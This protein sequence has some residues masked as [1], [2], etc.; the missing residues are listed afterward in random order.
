MPPGRL[1]C[2]VARQARSADVGA[3]R[4]DRARSCDADVAHQG[5]TAIALAAHA[6]KSLIDESARNAIESGVGL[7]RKPRPLRRIGAARAAGATDVGVFVHLPDKLQRKRRPL[8]AQLSAYLFEIGLL[9]RSFAGSRPEAS[10]KH[11]FQWMNAG[12]IG[13]QPPISQPNP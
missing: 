9:Q 1:A 8:S 4:I 6:P 5:R 2:I 10:S 12:H 7:E 11:R 13:P 3:D